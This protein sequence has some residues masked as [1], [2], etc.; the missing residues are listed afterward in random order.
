MPFG[1]DSNNDILI[2]SVIKNNDPNDNGI[3]AFGILR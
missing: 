2:F 1:T 3:N